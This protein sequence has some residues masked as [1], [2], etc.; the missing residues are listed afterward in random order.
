MIRTGVVLAVCVSVAA[1]AAAQVSGPRVNFD[2]IVSAQ[3]TR[4]AI[5]TPTSSATPPP[6]QRVETASP[7]LSTKDKTIY[8]LS[9]AAAAAG[10]AFNIHETR[11]ALDLNLGAKTFPLVWQETHDPADKGKVTATIL[12]ANGGLMV[13]SYILVRKGK[14]PLGSF[15]NFLIAGA[16]TAVSFHDRSVI[17]D[18]KAGK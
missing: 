13:V 17:N 18:A 9:L 5:Q 1:P 8:G 11:S 14:A 7:T 6:Q 16:T 2:K 15:L 3:A 4:L 10:T 12:A